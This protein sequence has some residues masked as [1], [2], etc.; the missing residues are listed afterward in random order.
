MKQQRSVF[1]HM[2]AT[3]QV[4]ESATKLLSCAKNKHVLKK[5]TISRNLKFA[6]A[7]ASVM[8]KESV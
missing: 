2:I 5:T 8:E 1:A 7:I 6:K 4:R 3:V